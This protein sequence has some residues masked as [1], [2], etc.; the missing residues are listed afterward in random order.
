M[1]KSAYYCVIVLSTCCWVDVLSADCC[2][3]M[4]NEKKNKQMFLPITRCG[5]YYNPSR[6]NIVTSEFEVV[7]MCSDSNEVA[8]TT[9]IYYAAS[10]LLVLVL[11]LAFVAR[12]YVDGRTS[13]DTSHASHGLVWLR[14][15]SV[16]QREARKLVKDGD[17]CSSVDTQCFG[18]RYVQLS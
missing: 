14:L 13:P 6:S 18:R 7:K 3:V 1:F 5:M 15:L 2:V 10:R 8:T 12:S 9:Y 4:L 17:T 11:G 16:H